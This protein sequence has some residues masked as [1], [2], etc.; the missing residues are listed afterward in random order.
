ML[1]HQYMVDG[2]VMVRDVWADGTNGGSSDGK[3]QKTEF[4]TLAVFTEGS[5]GTQFTALDVTGSFVT[6]RSQTPHPAVLWTFPPP[7][8]DDAQYMGQSWSDFSPRPPPI[9]PV[10]LATR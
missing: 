3:K 7:R 1:N 8:S 6:D 10:R 4:R 5:G 2:N 9:G